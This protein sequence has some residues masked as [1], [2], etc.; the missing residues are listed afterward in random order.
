MTR[1]RAIAALLPLL[2]VAP[3]ARAAAQPSA[4]PAPP[5]AA[6]APA[7]ARRITL[8]EAVALA[9]KGNVQVAIGAES[10]VQAEAS[11]EGTKAMRLPSL[12]LK[13]NL[14]VW[15]DDIVFAFELPPDVMLPFELGDSVVREQITS[16]V[17]VSV[18]QPITA[19]LVLG[20]L[21]RLEQ[22]G[23]DATRA[24]LDQT[25]LAVAFQAAET[26][27]GAL[28]TRT[29]QAIAE[30]SVQQIEAN[31]VRARALREAGILFDVDVLRLEAQR[32]SLLQQALE[33]Q[34]GAET[35][36]RGLSLLLGLPDGTELE[37]VDVDTQ[38]PPLPPEADAIAAARRQRPEIRAATARARQAE[39]GIDVARAQYLPSINAIASY[40]H[41]EGQGT[42]AV[43]DQAF[44]GLTL[45]WN[46]WDWGRRGAEVDK[47]RSQ[48]RQAKLARTFLDDQVAFEVRSAWLA[49]DVARRTLEV[50]QAGLRAAEEA[51]RLQN[52]RFA[53]GAA[54]TT[55]V[56]D[57][58]TEVARARAQATIA[59]YQYLLKWAALVRATGEVPTT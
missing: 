45:D 9:T 11:V 25:Q 28:Q 52:V 7:G 13:A 43:K 4:A 55:D 36:R 5:P 39:L 15:N 38:P 35:A 56:I 26:Y 37:L 48:S 8:A 30:T 58:E 54:T 19:A 1:A 32:D 46:L 17:E 34:V 18:V 2:L 44:I 29:L 3:A 20:K 53:E 57:A 23:V 14:F 21:V 6:E 16:T 27:L 24:E 10:I 59:R 22:A 50:A 42:F 49:A 47:A 40:S 41:N 12:G 31:L 33:A 51:Y